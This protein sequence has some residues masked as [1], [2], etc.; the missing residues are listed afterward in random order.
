[1]ALPDG[2][3]LTIGGRG[4]DLGWGVAVSDDSVEEIT[5]LSTGGAA[6]IGLE[7][8]PSSRHQH[9]CTLLGDGT[10]LVVGGLHQTASGSSALG[11]AYVFTPL[12]KD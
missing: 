3:V 11:D 1:V 6:V 8:L 12:P 9:T 5:S 10:V 2:R 7:R 4:V